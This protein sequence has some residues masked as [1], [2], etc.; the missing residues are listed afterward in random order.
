MQQISDFPFLKSNF[1]FVDYLVRCNLCQIILLPETVHSH[2]ESRHLNSSRH[3]DVSCLPYQAFSH[4]DALDAASK[5]DRGASS[6]RQKGSFKRVKRGSLTVDRESTPVGTVS[7]TDSLS[8]FTDDRVKRLSR[9][10]SED[11]SEKLREPVLLK[12]AR[13]EC[14]TTKFD[15]CKIA[16]PKTEEGN[17]FP[18]SDRSLWS[19]VYREGHTTSETDCEVAPSVQSSLL[20]QSVNGDPSVTE[21]RSSV[22]ANAVP[23]DLTSSTVSSYLPTHLPFHLSS[24]DSNVSDDVVFLGSTT[25][26]PGDQATRSISRSSVQPSSS[27][28]FETPVNC[29]SRST[30]N[31]NSY[32]SLKNR[33]L[34]RRAG[35]NENE[36]MQSSGSR[37]VPP[38]SQANFTDS[39]SISGCPSAHDN[40]EKGVEIDLHADPVC[41]IRTGKKVATCF[42]GESNLEVEIQKPGSANVSSQNGYHSWL[43]NARNL[44]ANFVNKLVAGNS[45]VLARQRCTTSQILSRRRI[46]PSDVRLAHEFTP[47]PASSSR[48]CDSTLFRKSTI[49]PVSVSPVE[50]SKN[51]VCLPNGSTNRTL[52]IV[53]PRRRS[54]G[55]EE[56]PIELDPSLQCRGCLHPNNFKHPHSFLCAVSVCFVNMCLPQL[57]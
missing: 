46:G 11:E 25:Q 39:A 3:H 31:A 42:S 21:P 45:D 10:P 20:E 15:G 27:S 32:N 1:S 51:A 41:H 56:S 49:P 2:Y 9:N 19:L 5:K 50:R 38:C 22:L 43:N 6:K 33:I 26:L 30:P 54:T 34:H 48:W 28:R 55:F 4:Y 29:G 12:L 36:H 44:Q 17:N 7:E 37:I 47:P 8:S 24:P 40:E 35:D 23:P 57:F 16:A 53:Y 14:C 13:S 18:P 52:D